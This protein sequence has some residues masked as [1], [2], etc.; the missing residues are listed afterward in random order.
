MKAV[1]DFSWEDFKWIKTYERAAN[2]RNSYFCQMKKLSLTLLRLY[3]FWMVYFFCLRAVFL[4]YHIQ[5]L[6]IEGITI[7]ESLYSFVAAL[8]L[9]LATASYIILPSFILLLFSALFAQGILRRLHHI[10]QYLLIFLFALVVGAELGLYSEWKSKLTAKALSHLSHPLEVFQTV[11]GLQ[12]TMLILIW[13]GLSFGGLFLYRLLARRYADSPPPLNVRAPISAL[14]LLPLIFL[15]ARGGWAAI[16]ASIS[17]A[18]FSKYPILNAASVN[19]LYNIGFSLLSAHQLKGENIF[20]TIDEA[21]AP[22]IVQKLHQ[23]EKDSTLNILKIKH[24]NIVVLLLESWSADLIESLGGEPGITPNFK[25]LEKDGLLFT[26][27]YAS[28]NRS[29]QAMGSLYAGLPGIP[30]THI[31]DHP[32]KYNALPSLIQKLKPEGYSSAFYFGGQLNY[33]NI[34]TFLLHNQI[35]VIVE[36]KD[37]PANMPRGRLGVHDGLLLPYAAQQMNGLKTPFFCTI[38]TLSSHSPYDYPMEQVITWPKLEKPFVNGGHYTDKAL[39]AFFDEAKKSSWYDQTLFVLMAD[40]SK[41][42]YRNHPLESFEHHKIPL[43]LC[44]PALKDE[45]RGKQM[46]MIC[47]NADVP[48]TL[49]RQLGL[50]SKE[51]FWS[52]NF[53]NRYYH[54][55]AYFELNEGLGWKTDEGYFVWNKFADTYFQKSLPADK[56]E[57]ILK[58]GKAYLQVLYGNF[59]NF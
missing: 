57:K 1:H 23:V 12:F 25:E 6:S 7:Q 20:A 26:R 11:S 4:L 35:D 41:T 55:F 37:L 16:P 45:F 51:F 46:D 39:K 30:I 32:E 53:L 42:T 52:K 2:V 18:S 8:K 9:D 15:G 14:W 58:E 47:G 10:F 17:S 36:G 13:L 50:E 44:G 21:K 3:L 48:A 5:L 33:G 40:H 31:A 54:P 38:F 22:D 43:L 56:E 19:S 59:L 49:L 34:L 27:F 28:A 29:Q 24:P